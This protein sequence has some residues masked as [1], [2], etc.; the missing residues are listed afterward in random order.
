MSESAIE[1]RLKRAVKA[2]GGKCIKLPAI[3]YRGIPD[4]LVLLPGGRIWFI[5]LK[6]AKAPTTKQV[7]V[8][9]SAWA[10]FLR[11]YG[12]N[13]VRIVGRGQL[14]E[15]IDDHVARAL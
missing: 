4:R 7:K 2:A 15:F 5:E 13:Y 1:G 8:H 10:T 3:W 6:K 11:D 12:F 14:E 9:Q